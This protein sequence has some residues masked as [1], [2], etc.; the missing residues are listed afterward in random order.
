MMQSQERISAFALCCRAGTHQRIDVPRPARE[1]DAGT[2]TGAT[3]G[4]M[5]LFR[6]SFSR[7]SIS[8]AQLLAVA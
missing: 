6:T 4:R 8:A 3:G 7:C 1:T 2:G 5:Q